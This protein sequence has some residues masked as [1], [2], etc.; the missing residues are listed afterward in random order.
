MGPLNL[1]TRRQFLRACSTLAVGAGLTPRALLASPFERGAV[2]LDAISFPHFS[3]QIGT[4]FR[5]W[6]NSA[7]VVSL[8]LIEAQP[9]QVPDWMTLQAEDGL[10]EKFSLLFVGPTDVL[11][12]QDTH[13]FEHPR[14]GR[15]AMFIAPI[16]FPSAEGCYY[17]AIFNRNLVRRRRPWPKTLMQRNTGF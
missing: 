4:P 9:R 1:A 7:P 8:I 10:N 14:I 17:E 15:F 11:L 3:A 13:I 12:E 2:S 5:V 16:L 6:Q